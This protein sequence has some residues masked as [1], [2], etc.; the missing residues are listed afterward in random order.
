MSPSRLQ[1]PRTGRTIQHVTGRTEENKEMRLRKSEFS[2]ADITTWSG[3]LSPTLWLLVGEIL[4][5]FRLEKNSCPEW[6]WKTSLREYGKSCF[7]HHIQGHYSIS[8]G[9]QTWDT[10]ILP[11]LHSPALGALGFLLFS[12][13]LLLSWSEAGK[14]N[15]YELNCHIR[16]HLWFKIQMLYWLN[17]N[18]ILKL[19]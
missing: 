11:A 12:F 18:L 9:K 14:K 17:T 8:Y 15:W 19:P 3:M 13:A 1:M 6:G 4:G 7:A 5:I 10:I 16:N 2:D